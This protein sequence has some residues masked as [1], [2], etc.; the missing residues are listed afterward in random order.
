MKKSEK[1]VTGLLSQGLQISGY[2]GLIRVKNYPI[3]LTRVS[4]F[5]KVQGDLK[6]SKDFFEVTIVLSRKN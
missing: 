2:E 5:A 3:K 4:N 1:Y 6:K